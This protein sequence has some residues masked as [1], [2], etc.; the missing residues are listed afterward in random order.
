MVR[1]SACQQ[2]LSDTARFCQECGARVA[3]GAVGDTE[4]RQLTVTR[5]EAEHG[6]QI[7]ARVGSHTGPVVVGEMGGGEK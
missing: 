3:V 5:I 2:E 4:R 6:L 7:A 1:C